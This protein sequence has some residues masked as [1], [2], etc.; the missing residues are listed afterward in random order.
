M[1]SCSCDPGVAAFTGAVAQTGRP[2]LAHS[3][4]ELRT[5]LA[6]R[7]PGIAL[8]LYGPGTCAAATANPELDARAGP[9]VCSPQ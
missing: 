7:S 2:A 4:L 6:A 3:G 1:N 8:E 9:A 5:R